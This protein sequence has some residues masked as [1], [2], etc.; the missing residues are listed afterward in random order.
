MKLLL[1]LL[2]WDLILNY[3]QG[4]L[5]A[6]LWVMIVWLAVLSLI[7][8]SALLP[9]LISL[10]FLELSIFAMYLMPSFY[11]LEKTERVFDSLVTTPAPAWLWLAS[12][13][14][15]FSVQTLSISAVIV[16]LVYGW[17]LH[18]GWFAAGVIYSGLPLILLGFALATRYDGITEFLFPSIPLLVAMQLPLLSYWQV[19]TGW[20]FWL[21]PTMPGVVLLEAAFDGGHLAR[22]ISALLWGL[23]YIVPL[24]GLALRQFTQSAV[25]R[26]GTA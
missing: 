7:P 10:L 17:Y 21:L 16:L 14:L 20:Y 15:L 1:S 18:W 19:I 22:S 5:Y 23:I 2:R 12:K 24:F 3:R 11:Y 13:C 8:E 26:A 25:R 4:I 9:L 6:A